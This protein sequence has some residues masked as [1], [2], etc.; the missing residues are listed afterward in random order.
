MVNYCNNLDLKSHTWAPRHTHPIKVL[1]YP[2]GFGLLRHEYVK[3]PPPCEQT[4]S[5][6]FYDC[7]W[8]KQIQP[9]HLSTI[10]LPKL[11]NICRETASNPSPITILTVPGVT[12]MTHQDV[13]NV[14]TIISSKTIPNLR[15]YLRSSRYVL[16]HIL[17]IIKVVLH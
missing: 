3:H 16:A 2:P 1:I 10:L 8:R 5:T 9:G 7:F 15:I 13:S 4:S 12:V 17:R 14:A 6:T 11:Q